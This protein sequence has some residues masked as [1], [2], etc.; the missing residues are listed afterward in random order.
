MHGGRRQCA[1][2]RDREEA[3][4]KHIQDSLA[5]LPA[6]DAHA[7]A[8]P[9]G[10]ALRLIDVGSGAGFPGIILALARPLW[11]V[12]AHDLLSICST[13]HACAFRS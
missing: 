5:L 12:Q 6:L 11:Q 2:V 9:D 8:V 3:I 4:E 13:C 10:G 7:P 1:A